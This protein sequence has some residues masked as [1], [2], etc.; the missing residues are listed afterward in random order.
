MYRNASPA[1]AAHNGHGPRQPPVESSP[2]AIETLVAKAQTGD[3]EA[4]GQIYDRYNETVYRFVYFRVGG[5]RPLAE[6]LT[7]DTF[8]RALKHIS[9]FTWQGSDLGAWLTTIARR[10]VIDH[11]K[12][13][14]TRLE[15]PTGEIYDAERVDGN[16]EGSPEDAVVR[17]ITN[18]SLLSAVKELNPDQQE[19]I[20]L[21][22]L[23]GLSVSETALAMGRNEGAVK[24]LQYRAV[25]SLQRLLPEGFRPTL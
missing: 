21:R 19:C 5:N 9:N 1:S 24:A 3:P 25:R 11:F 2:V 16:L 13:S 10:I 12:R 18:V 7:A 20:V 22:F 4:F 23:Q 14:R 17:H 8:L 15:V 6:D